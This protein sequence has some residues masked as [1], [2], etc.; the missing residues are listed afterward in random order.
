M[1]AFIQN[2]NLGEILV[3]SIVAVVIFG[4]D[5]P[6]VMVDLAGYVYKARRALSDLRRQTGIDQEFRQVDYTMRRTA[7]EAQEALER[8]ALDEQ[9]ELDEPDEP[10]GREE[11]RA[12]GEESTE[13]PV[14]PGSARP[15]D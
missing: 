4:R 3:I 7:R 13:P 15:A 6:R 11:S 1:L 8:R 12:A 2:L 10:E 9:G 14:E 5:L